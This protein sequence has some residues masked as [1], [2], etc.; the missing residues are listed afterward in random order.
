MIRCSSRQESGKIHDHAV[1]PHIVVR[2]HQQG[3][4]WAIEELVERPGAL[5]WALRLRLY[6]DLLTAQLFGTA[7]SLNFATAILLCLC[8]VGRRHASTA[9][10]RATALYHHVR[11]GED[12]LRDVGGF[13]GFV[14]GVGFVEDLYSAVVFHQ[15]ATDGWD[16]A[17]EE[18]EDER[19][20]RKSVTMAHLE[21]VCH[22]DISSAEAAV[23]LKP[24]AFLAAA[25]QEWKRNRERRNGGDQE[26][27]MRADGTG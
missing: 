7:L 11:C 2:R 4:L 15:E 20:E 19:D 24:Q 5:A 9:L 16:W 13:E 18:E 17:V 21:G 25:E 23:V 26:K 8:S 6:S 10:A 14:E 3:S 1:Q 27:M 12:D 22:G